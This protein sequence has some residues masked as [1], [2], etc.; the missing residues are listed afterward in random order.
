[1]LTLGDLLE[2]KALGLVLRTGPPE[3]AER[4]VLGG[5]GLRVDD[6][7]ALAPALG[8]ALVRPGPTSIEVPA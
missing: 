6:P 4:P 2:E 8:E 3:A 7:A 1:M 5:T